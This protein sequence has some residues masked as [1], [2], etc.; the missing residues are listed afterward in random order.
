MN[1]TNADIIGSTSCRT[2]VPHSTAAAVATH[3]DG[4]AH[5]DAS[6]LLDDLLLVMVLYYGCGWR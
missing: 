1:G 5:D 4:D 6:F 3:A 2:I